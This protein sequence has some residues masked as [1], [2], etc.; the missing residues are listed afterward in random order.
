MTGSWYMSDRFYEIPA[1]IARTLDVLSS[2]IAR[3][4]AFESDIIPKIGK[5]ET[6]VLIPIQI[7]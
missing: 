2:M 1:R 5:T 4:D 7:L 6:S 3:L